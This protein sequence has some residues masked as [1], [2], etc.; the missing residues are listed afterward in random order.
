LPFNVPTLRRLE[1]KGRLPRRKSLRLAPVR[2]TDRL[3]CPMGPHD[4]LDRTWLTRQRMHPDGPS[5]RHL[6]PALVKSASR[7]LEFGLV[8][9][10]VAVCPTRQVLVGGGYRVRGGAILHAVSATADSSGRHVQLLTGDP[11]A[12]YGG[13]TPSEVVI[14]YALCAQAV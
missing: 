3:S 9:S 6:A 5:K 1:G 7:T 12:S 11:T 13:S 2:L 10:V 14:A 4:P 8:S